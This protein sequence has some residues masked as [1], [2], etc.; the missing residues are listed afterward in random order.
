[1]KFNLQEQRQNALLEVEQNIKLQKEQELEM[2]GKLKFNK[3]KL[4]DDLAQQQIQTDKE[5]EKVQQK[6][7]INR[8]KLLSYIHKG[9]LKKKFNQI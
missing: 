4:L 2:Q 3:L 7:D 1:M 6:R 8:S 5:V 9:K